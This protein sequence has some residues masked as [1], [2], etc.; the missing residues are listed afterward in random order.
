MSCPAFCFTSLS[1]ITLMIIVMVLSLLALLGFLLTCYIMKERHSIY[2]NNHGI[3]SGD[4]IRT[5]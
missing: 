5:Q 2:K 4:E 3:K 1:K